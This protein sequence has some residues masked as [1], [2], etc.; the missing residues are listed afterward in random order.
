[1][2]HPMLLTISLL[3]CLAFNIG[4]A[5]AEA[6]SQPS[7]QVIKKL[8]INAAKVEELINIQGLGQKKAEAIV[9]FI[10]ANGPISSLDTLVEIKGIG[11]RLLKKITPYIEVTDIAK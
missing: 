7:V 1:M 2:K 8:D 5:Y 3:F 6:T 4:L 10:R 11:Q 9:R